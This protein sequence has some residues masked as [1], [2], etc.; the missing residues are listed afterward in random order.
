[1]APYADAVNLKAVKIST[2]QSLPGLS[3]EGILG[4][5]IGNYAVKPELQSVFQCHPPNLVWFENFALKTHFLS[6]YIVVCR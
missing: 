4:N 2:S 3:G 1:M 6:V 5:Q